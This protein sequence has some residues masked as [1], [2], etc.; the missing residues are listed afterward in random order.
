M[1]GL[2]KDTLKSGF[3]TTMALGAL[4]GIVNS[5]LGE[6]DPKDLVKAINENTSLW[7][8]AGNEISGHAKSFPI[9]DLSIIS[10]VRKV[11]DTQ[12][13]GFPNVVLNYL[14]Q[15]RVVLYNIIVNA[16][17]NKGRIWLAN[18]IE[19]ILDGVQNGK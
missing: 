4:R 3:L 8:I 7:G 14:A 6:V 15:D 13:G 5:A 2:T 10:D 9:S 18:Q 12:Y 16:P 1:F 11:V 17:D 19:E